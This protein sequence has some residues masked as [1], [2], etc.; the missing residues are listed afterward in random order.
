LER[1]QVAGIGVGVT[2]STIHAEAALAAGRAT[3]RLAFVHECNGRGN[4]GTATV[5]AHD[6]KRGA[7]RVENPS[8]RGFRA[9]GLRP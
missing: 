8:A 9:A 5:F 1:R 2:E 6:L 7:G 3:V 4:G